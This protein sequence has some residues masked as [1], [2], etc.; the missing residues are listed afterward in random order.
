MPVVHWVHCQKYVVELWATIC[1]VFGPLVC[2]GGELSYEIQ[3]A[4]VKQC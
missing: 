1:F 4:E 2:L 3:R